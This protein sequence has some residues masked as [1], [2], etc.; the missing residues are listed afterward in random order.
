MFFFILNILMSSSLKIISYNCQSLNVNAVIVQDLLHNCDI[1]CLQET[2]IDENNCQILDNLDANFMTAYVPAY[3]KPGCFVGRSSRG[4]AI[5]WRRSTTFA[6]TPITYSRRIMGL[7]IM[8]QNNYEILLL[9]VY[10]TCDYGTTDCLIEY[11]SSLAELSNIIES[12]RFNEFYCAGDFNADPTKGR[13]YA[14]VSQFLADNF[15]KCSDVDSLPTDSYTYISQ[16]S[17]CATSWVDHVIC[18]GISPISCHEI[19]YGATFSDH[20]PIKF[21]VKVPHLVIFNEGHLPFPAS[22]DHRVDWERVSDQEK[23]EYSHNLDELCMLMSYD[24]FLCQEN[25]CK[26]LNHV[27]ELNKIYFDIN[28]AIFVASLHLPSQKGPHKGD[29][30]VGWND[31]CRE[32]YA[33]ARNKYLTWHNNG[34][35]RVGVHFEEMKAA[36]SAF[37][38]ALN[39][40]KKHEQKI[41]RENLLRKFCSNNKSKFWKDVSKINGNKNTN[42]VHIDGKTDKHDINNIFD[43]KYKRI[44]DDPNSQARVNTNEQAPLNLNNGSLLSHSDVSLAISQL[45]VGLGWDGIHANH[46]K[47]SGRVFKNLLFKFFN[48]LINHSFVPERMAF[49]EIRPVVKNASLGKHDSDNYRPVMN[50]SMFLKILEYCLLPIL[51]K[52]LQISNWQFGFRQNTGCLPAIALV[53]ETIFRYNDENTNVHCVMIDLSKAFDRINHAILFQKLMATGLDPR[54][55]EILRGMYDNTYVSTSFNMVKSQSW[56]VNNGARQGGVLSPLIFAFY[57]NHILETILDLPVGCSLNGYKTNIL[58][59]ADDIIVMA[60]S[61]DGVQRILNVLTGMLSELCLTVNVLKSQYVIF[62]SNARKVSSSP[63]ILMNGVEVKEVSQCKYLGV[64]LSGDGSMK[65]DIDRALNS[66][67]KQFNAMYSKFYFT[68]KEVL[69][70]LFKSFTSSFYGIE[71]WC[72]NIPQYQLNYISVAYHKAIKKISGLNVWDSNHLGCEIA[73]V[74]IF[75]HMLARRLVCFWHRLF[76]SKSPCMANLSYYWRYRSC[77]FGR[78][79][80]LFLNR[81]S[82]DIADNPLCAILARIDF[83]QRHEPR[84]HYAQT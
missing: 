7:K 1:L 32:S 77:M 22:S 74:R 13:F 25:G 37:K 73:D 23:Q 66:F 17:T 21:E 57:I 42:V 69:F 72:S 79:S 39:F 78:I 63:K 59:Y 58:C 29:R 14:H 82:V 35:I 46:L 52:N 3:R 20:I 55:I 48:T 33:V 54:V 34:R 76:R 49:G 18:R 65:H 84:S 40:C 12:E 51:S 64:I 9:N 61:A 6:C 10:L 28:E 75:K 44:L 38:N 16:N 43:R 15:L 24:A 62:W 5:C 67:L 50:S 36:R 47:L 4:L 56:R 60:P 27:R 2:L 41:K 68:N 31:Y 30:V 80:E 83:I 19:L 45:N 26:N 71:L 11:K 70:Y 53:K 8:L 81:Y